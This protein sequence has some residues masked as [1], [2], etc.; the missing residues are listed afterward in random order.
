MEAVRDKEVKMAKESGCFVV[1]PHWITAVSPH[2]IGFSFL[3]LTQLV[4]TMY[5]CCRQV[6]YMLYMYLLI[7]YV[8]FAVFRTW[9]QST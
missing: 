5:M 3:L 7:W 1:S 2:P 9:I 8:I 4:T 6:I